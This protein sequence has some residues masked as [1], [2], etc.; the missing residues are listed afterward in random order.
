MLDILLD[1]PSPH[2]IFIHCDSNK[3]G[4][5]GHASGLLLFELSQERSLDEKKGNFFII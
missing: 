4:V 3:I 5:Y 2:S 1:I